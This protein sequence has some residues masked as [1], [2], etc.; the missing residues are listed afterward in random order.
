MKKSQFVLIVDD[1]RD[2][3]E[4]VADLFL[5]YGYD[6]EIIANG[7]LAL[8]RAR[9]ADFD[10]AFMDVQMPVMNGVDSFFEIRKLKPAARI[11]MMAGAHEP[12]VGR[13]LAA[14]ANGLL[15]KP[16]AF[17]RMLEIVETAA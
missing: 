15:E 14:G 9:R 8:D 12:L 5:A 6:V 10:I 17:E 16:F 11:V 1:D 13:A 2:W 4:S 3:A 7:K